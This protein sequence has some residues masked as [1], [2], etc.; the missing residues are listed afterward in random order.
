M[1][2]VHN[3]TGEILMNE[4]KTPNG[5]IRQVMDIYGLS[6]TQMATTLSKIKPLKLGITRYDVYNYINDKCM[7]PADKYNKIISLLDPKYINLV[8]KIKEGK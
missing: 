1:Y 3:S 2:D 6:C 8:I 7:P 5:D 4:L